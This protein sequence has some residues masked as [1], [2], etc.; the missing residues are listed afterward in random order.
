MLTFRTATTILSLN[1]GGLKTK[2]R[3]T[4]LFHWLIQSTQAD[5]F[6]IQ[7]TH[8]HPAQE[9]EEWT[10]EWAGY[11]IATNTDPNQRASW[12]SESDSAYSGGTAILLRP[13]RVNSIKIKSAT[14]TTQFRGG[15]TSVSAVVDLTRV[16]LHSIYAPATP[17]TRDE[18]FSHLLEH[19]PDDGGV[20]AIYGGD[21]NCVNIPDRD[22]RNMPQ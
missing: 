12:W 9:K 6:L 7:E 16:S 4:Q 20:M 10:R 11:Q 13:S 21:Y 22:T 19:P 2:Q 15:R 5:I 18:F 8:L 3:R 17:T 1:V 14:T